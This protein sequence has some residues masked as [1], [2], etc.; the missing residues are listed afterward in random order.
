M[1][2]KSLGNE[3]IK[4]TVRDTDYDKSKTLENV[5]YFNYLSSQDV[6]LHVQLNTG[7][8][9]KQQHSTRGRLFSSAN[10]T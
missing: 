4:A 1:W 3:I 8:P 10:W 7:F 9:W 2:K 5:E 6:G